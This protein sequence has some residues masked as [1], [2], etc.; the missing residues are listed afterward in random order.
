VFDP[1][2]FQ[3]FRDEILGQRGILSTLGQGGTIG[4]L[5]L[6]SVEPQRMFDLAEQARLSKLAAQD[7]EARAGIA[8]SRTV[9]AGFREL[10]KLGYIPASAEPSERDLA[11]TLLILEHSKPPKLHDFGGPE[12]AYLMSQMQMH[13]AND[14]P[15]GFARALGCEPQISAV[16]GELHP[17]GN[18]SE[19][20]ISDEDLFVMREVLFCTSKRNAVPWVL[21]F[22]L[23]HLQ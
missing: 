11:G 22:K 15:A 6:E 9:E 14:L 7:A 21:G 5:Q 18:P 3:W 10:W 8:S 1:W 16:Q 2:Y 23:G 19:W 17:I 13:P 4:P 12:E 20:E